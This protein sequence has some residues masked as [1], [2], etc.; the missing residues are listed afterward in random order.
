V[1]GL[2]HAILH[3]AAWL[4]PADRRAEW[5]AEWRSELWYVERRSGGRPTAFCLGAF[6]DALWLRRNAEGGTTQMRL[7]S[8]VRCLG[9]LAILATVAV[10]AA[11]NLPEA[12]AILVPSPYPDPRGLVLVWRGGGRVSE[13][14]STS[15]GAYRLLADHRQG[16]FS[17]VAFYRRL[18]A[19]K[20]MEVAVGS[21][22]LFRVLGMPAPSRGLV[23]SDRAWR[24]YFRSDP[25]IEGRAI[26]IGGRATII[27]GVLPPDAWRF[28]GA[29]D[30]WLLDDD[31]AVERGPGFVVARLPKAAA[32]WSGP[33]LWPISVPDG[34]GGVV[35]YEC[36]RLTSSRPV[37][38]LLW[39]L[40]VGL[41][42]ASTVTSFSLG[43]YGGGTLA[44]R[45]RRWIFLTVKL[46]LLLPI[47]VCGSL[48]LGAILTMGLAV[49]G[50][51]AGSVFAFRW[52]L[53]DQRKRCPVCL[54]VL[55]SPTRIG[56]ASHAF[57]AWYGT[58]LICGRGH[59]LL[60]V[61]EI[62]TSSYWTQ[63]WTD[64]DASWRELFTPASR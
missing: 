9:L 44:T 52:A 43:E 17:G 35:R 23:I 8:A 14:P 45:S 56:G 39:L 37:L 57:L 13:V 2:R 11:L 38:E 59:G 22:N 25:R 63:R 26:E 55:S 18:C 12:R 64:L 36:F 1:I 30:G 34:E 58:E 7:D 31:R 5:L 28:A 47:V 32:S 50:M 3:C 41:L 24:K 15:A 27:A 40:A 48:A 53:I 20:G 42:V 10:V 4:A 54:R 51:L 49:H 60:H 46:A 29:F 19:W 62:R 33:S 6:R 21:A 61:P 16:H